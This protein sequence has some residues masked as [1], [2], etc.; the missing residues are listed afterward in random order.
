M[1]LPKIVEILSGNVNLTGLY[2]FEFR[3]KDDQFLTEVF[4]LLPPEEVSVTEAPRSA[5]HPTLTGGYLVDFGNDFKEISIRG[6]CHFFYANVPGTNTYPVLRE[7]ESPPIINGYEEWIKLRFL[8][9]RYR[10]YTMT[11][12]GKLGKFL[13]PFAVLNNPGMI[14]TIA[15][16]DKV[17]RNVGARLGAL[18]DQIKLVFHDF[19]EDN[20]FYVKVDSFKGTRSKSD[21]YTVMYDIALKAYRVDETRYGLSNA[22][23]GAI[24][25]KEPAWEYM[26]KIQIISGD[27]S[28][29]TVPSEIQYNA[30]EESFVLPATDTPVASDSTITFGTEGGYSVNKYI[31]QELLA[32]QELLQISQRLSFLR[33]ELQ[34]AVATAQTQ[35]QPLN[36]VIGTLPQQ[37]LDTVNALKTQVENY[38]VPQ[39][40]FDD[41][42]AGAIAFSEVASF[43]VMAYY[44][45]LQKLEISL[46]G[47]EVALL[48]SADTKTQA[49]NPGGGS[50]I[51]Y[52]GI[53][54]SSEFDDPS[55]DYPVTN[56]P[57]AYIYYRVIEGE[58]SPQ[59]AAKVFPDGDYSR[60]PAILELNG[61]TESDLLDGNV[62]PGTLI[63]IP[64]PGD[65]SVQA[66]DNM[67]F[68]APIENPTPEQ[69]QKFLY[70]AEVAM[71]DGKFSV[72]AGGDLSVVRGKDSVIQSWVLRFNRNEGE[73][74][75]LHPKD[76]I[77]SINDYGSDVPYAVVLE[78]LVNDIR[79]K[80]ELD[81]RI[82]S[83]S[84]DLNT[85]RIDGDKVFVDTQNYLIGGDNFSQPVNVKGA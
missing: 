13:P 71:R 43:D 75:P 37:V 18:A 39:E 30:G 38:A 28:P 56:L 63:K 81:P 82:A 84:V 9:S 15:L 10:D 73:L 19:D 22:G 41:F 3:N 46:A 68:E 66:E 60:W 8:L 70:G 40:V 57:Q 61:I 74:S 52:L 72:S 58:T 17:K 64:L 35:T 25:K 27:F 23:A 67:V 6:Q 26:R 50:G 12:G 59:I 11:P 51:G 53:L 42:K 36:K 2:S 78:R 29:A 24:T 20:H 4:L 69:L 31:P 1:S 45:E 49:L 21:P 83:A 79:V 76:G 5:L 77:L 55:F 48:T 16:I 32:S 62:E 47:Y 65:V 85:L 7:N 44:N 34:K 54:N 14:G 80:T 33:G